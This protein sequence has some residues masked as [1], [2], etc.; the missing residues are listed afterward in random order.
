MALIACKECNQPVS[1]QA[2]VCMNCGIRLKPHLS[3]KRIALVGTVIAVIGMLWGYLVHSNAADANAMLSCEA[4]VIDELNAR[5]RPVFLEE[6]TESV[7]WH[8]IDVSGTVMAPDP[9]QGGIGK[10]P[11][12]CS[13]D[14]VH[15]KVVH[16]SL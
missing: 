8:A 6:K 7:N 15:A 9:V 10:R 4:R 13:Y 14:T 3:R 16:L 12:H 2:P 1:D 5:I 11:F